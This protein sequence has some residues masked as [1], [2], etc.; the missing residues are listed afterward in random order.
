[1]QVE[2]GS[3]AGSLEIVIA[4]DSAQLE[5]A[6][7]FHDKPAAAAQIK[8]KPDP[9]TPYNRTLIQ[10]AS[11]DQNGHFTITNIAPGKYQVTA[12][13]PGD[14]GSPAATSEPKSIT[15]TE[16]D[17]QSLQ[18]TAEEPKPSQ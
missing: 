14:S 13:L 6:V 17:R 18:L 15:L 9:T 5:G 2:K 11:T 8:L 4:S 1:M 10:A 16:K 7:I 12:K 3:T